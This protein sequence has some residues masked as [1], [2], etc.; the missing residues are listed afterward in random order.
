MKSLEAQLKDLMTKSTKKEEAEETTVINPGLMTRPMITAGPGMMG[1]AP[2]VYMNG[3]GMP[4]QF[5][6]FGGY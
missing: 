5:T 3:N 1:G 6:G 4:P 2:P